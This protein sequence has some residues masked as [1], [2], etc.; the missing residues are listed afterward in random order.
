MKNHMQT[1][2]KFVVK[3]QTPIAV[4]VTA[5]LCLCINRWA[6]SDHNNFLKEHDLYDLYHN[7]T[8]ID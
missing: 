5:T 7:I 4:V 8:P 1:A 2:K 3:Y 6:L